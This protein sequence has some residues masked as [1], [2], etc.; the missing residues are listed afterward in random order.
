[1]HTGPRLDFGQG[2]YLTHCIGNHYAWVTQSGTHV[3]YVTAEDIEIESTIAA[4]LLKQ[5]S[6]KQ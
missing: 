3:D 2:R 5:R 6:Y 4:E 1:M